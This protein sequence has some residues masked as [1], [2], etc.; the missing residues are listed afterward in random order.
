[1]L[2][3][4]RTCGTGR[5]HRGSGPSPGL[6][7]LCRVSSAGQPIAIP[8]MRHG[9]TPRPVCPSPT[10]VPKGHQS[11]DIRTPPRDDPKRGTRDD[12]ANER[13]RANLG[14]NEDR[15]GLWWRREIDLAHT[16]RHGTALLGEDLGK[17]VVCLLGGDQLPGGVRCRRSR[18]P[19]EV[20]AVRVDPDG[21]SLHELV[22]HVNDSKGGPRTIRACTGSRKSP[23]AGRSCSGA[24]ETADGRRDRVRR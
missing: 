24:R 23:P 7:N 19:G 21:L 17:A 6:D 1:M 11:A 20:R 9:W 3:I 8:R 14:G 10:S 13:E 16:G 12:Q 15:V 4:A 2:P 18:P 5:R 22:A